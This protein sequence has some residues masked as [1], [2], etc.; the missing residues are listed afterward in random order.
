MLYFFFFNIWLLI[1]FKPHP[2]LYLYPRS[3]QAQKKA[4]MLPL[5]ALMDDSNHIDSCSHHVMLLLAPPL[6]II[7]NYI[8]PAIIP[9]LSSCLNAVT[10]GCPALPRDLSHVSYETSYP[11]C[12]YGIILSIRNQILSQ[13]PCASAGNHKSKSSLYW[14][15]QLRA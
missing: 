14:T 4:L 1:P 9:A 5:W 15:T 7:S 10:E 8:I 13:G 2:S 6:T 3:M 12:I 11:W